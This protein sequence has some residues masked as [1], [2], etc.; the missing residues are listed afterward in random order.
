MYSWSVGGICV[1]FADG[2]LSH[3]INGKIITMKTDTKGNYHFPPN[4]KPVSA[5]YNIKADLSI[6]ATLQLE[7]CYRGGLQALAFVVCEN[8]RPPFQFK[9]AS[10]KDYKYSFSVTH[11]FIETRCFSR[12]AIVWAN[13]SVIWQMPQEDIKC[14]AYYRVEKTHVKVNVVVVKELDAHYEVCMIQDFTIGQAL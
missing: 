5:I 11:G 13:W 10:Q 2:P 8:T 14:A 4:C 7:H 12:W 6:R 1:Y 3:K 9:L